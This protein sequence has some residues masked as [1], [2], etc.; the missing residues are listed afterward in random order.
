MEVPDAGF[1]RANDG[2]AVEE[3]FRGMV[4]KGLLRW[5]WGGGGGRCGGWSGGVLPAVTYCLM[6]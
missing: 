5:V 6:S 2:R 1:P 3:L 4:V